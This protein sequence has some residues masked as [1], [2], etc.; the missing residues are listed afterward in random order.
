MSQLTYRKSVKITLK[1]IKTCKK[2]VYYNKKTPK[3]KIHKRN[4][5][6]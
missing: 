5:D 1:L 2:K 3:E 4:K 6:G